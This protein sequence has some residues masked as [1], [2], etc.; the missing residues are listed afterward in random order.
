MGALVPE[1]LIAEARELAALDDFGS[2]SF[3]EGLAVYAESAS[4]EAQLN[5]LGETAIRANIVGSL[6]NRLRIVDWAQQHPAVADERI[7]APIVV[8]GMFRAGTTFLSYVL[9]QDTRNRALLRWESGDSV[10]PPTPADFR[11]GPRVEAAR[12]GND[13]LEQINPRIRAIHHEEPDGPTECISL[14]SQDF[15]SLSWEA[16]SNV[17]T[18]GQWLLGVDQRS[19]YEYHRLALQVLQSGGVRGRWTLKSPHHA[20]NLEAL[21][22]VYPDARLVLLHRDPVVLCASVCSLINTLSSTF[23]D[24]D[25]RAYVAEHWV[26]MLEESI[27]RIDRFRAAHPEHPIVDVQYT[28]LMRDPVG[29]V[30][31]I[32]AGCRD[33][34]D[35]DRTW[36]AM[37]TY[38]AAHPKDS[39]GVHRY[40]L[41]E[42]GL[43]AAELAERFSGYTERYGVTPAS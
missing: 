37:A 12:M 23:T 1:E 18:Y 11:T 27:R 17:P 32:Y 35:D 26:A 14:M 2:D 19:A 7:D 36:D 34:H 3:R 29:T 4:T 8:I 20:L 15:K 41:S 30:R 28:D 21:T 16:I 33:A 40:D 38:V 43:D 22:S 39:L 5:E 25:H 24:V 6:T 9:E 42:F 31:S 10:P 13:M